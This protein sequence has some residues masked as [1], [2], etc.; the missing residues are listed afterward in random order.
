MATS[1]ESIKRVQSAPWCRINLM[2]LEDRGNLLVKSPL[3]GQR[4]GSP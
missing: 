2:A 4:A 1:S 3:E